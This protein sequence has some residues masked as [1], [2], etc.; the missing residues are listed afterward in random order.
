LLQ[1]YVPF[2]S[3]VGHRNC[4]KRVFSGGKKEKRR[5]HDRTKRKKEKALEALSDRFGCREEFYCLA[6]IGNWEK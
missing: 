5:C 4:V 2:Y 6:I 1:F 3:A